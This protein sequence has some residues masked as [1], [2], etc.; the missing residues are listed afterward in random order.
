MHHQTKTATVEIPIMS[1]PFRLPMIRRIN[2]PT[3]PR[4]ANTVESIQSTAVRPDCS[5]LFSGCVSSLLK[6]D[7]QRW[8]FSLIDTPQNGQNRAFW[9][10]GDGVGRTSGFGVC[11]GCRGKG[12][13]VSGISNSFPHRPHRPNRPACSLVTSK[14]A[15]QSQEKRMVA[16][17]GSSDMGIPVSVSSEIER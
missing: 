9:E 2:P 12:S 4:G 8:A 6:Q 11:C 14:A 13:E 7:G 16:G 15:P 1:K 10:A 5:S 3:H 17:E